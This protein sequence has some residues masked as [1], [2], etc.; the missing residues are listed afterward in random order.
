VER[1]RS[2]FHGGIYC[3]NVQESKILSNTVLIDGSASE[4]VPRE[5]GPPVLCVG[6]GETLRSV[7]SQVAGMKVPDAIRKVLKLRERS[8]L[9]CS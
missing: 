2:F 6:D 7:A 8:L 9:V 4:V 5:P 1:L 3:L